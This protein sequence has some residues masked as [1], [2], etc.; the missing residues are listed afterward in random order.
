MANMHL[1]E[2]SLGIG[3]CWI[4]GKLRE[5]YIGKSTEEYLREF[6]K[7]PKK[8]RLEVILSQ[9]IPKVHPE[10]RNLQKLPME[11]FSSDD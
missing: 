8:Y 3:G 10:I 7:F 9:G 11:K 1:M 5:A 2:D 6:L 4:Q